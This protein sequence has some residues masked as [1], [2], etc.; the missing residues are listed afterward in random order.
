MGTMTD[1]D[2]RIERVE[3]VSLELDRELIVLTVQNEV[4]TATL[5]DDG[6]G[7]SG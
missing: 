4:L 7:F 5:E 3:L 6:E 2:L 1:T